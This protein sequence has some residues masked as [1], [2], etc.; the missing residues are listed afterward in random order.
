MFSMLE[1][2]PYKEAF[3]VNVSLAVYNVLSLDSDSK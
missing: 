2:F 1:T 3:T